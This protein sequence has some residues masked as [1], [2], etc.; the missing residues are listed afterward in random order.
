MKQNRTEQN[1]EVWAGRHSRPVET[2][3]RQNKTET[4]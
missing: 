4:E 3:T 2:E 1:K